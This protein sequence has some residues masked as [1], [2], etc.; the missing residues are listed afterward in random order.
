MLLVYNFNME[1]ML[2]SK[3]SDFSKKIKNFIVQK[4]ILNLFYTLED[5]KC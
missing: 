2:N 3:T 5:L 4:K 1:I